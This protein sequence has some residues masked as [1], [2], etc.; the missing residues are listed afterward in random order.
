MGVVLGSEREG[1]IKTGDQVIP[2]LESSA[3]EFGL[4]L[5][6]CQGA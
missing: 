2:G 3:E 4:G 5:R 6:G 1:W